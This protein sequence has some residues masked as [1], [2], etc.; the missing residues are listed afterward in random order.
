VSCCVSTGVALDSLAGTLKLLLSVKLFF[1]KGYL[2]FLFLAQ[3]IKL[4]IVMKP[5]YE[6][7]VYKNVERCTLRV[8]FC[9][10]ETTYFYLKSI[11]YAWTRS[12]IFQFQL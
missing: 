1:K 9:L 2:I 4:V 8:V 12:Y 11:F 10:V 5:G 3:R 7:V 6:A